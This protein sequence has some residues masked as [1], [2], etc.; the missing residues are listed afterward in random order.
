MQHDRNDQSLSM[1]EETK[2]PVLVQSYW[3]AQSVSQN[4]CEPR[5][6]SGTGMIALLL[7]DPVAWAAPFTFL[8]L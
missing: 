3:W 2:S 1:A 7:D 8:L 6:V 5:T 4:V